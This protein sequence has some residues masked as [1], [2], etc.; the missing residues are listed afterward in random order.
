M[1][2]YAIL[3]AN[4]PDLFDN[5]RGTLLRDGS[6]IDPGDMIHCDGSAAPLTNIYPVEMTAADWAGWSSGGHPSPEVETASTL[7]F[8]CRS[9][10]WVAEVSRMLSEDLAVPIWV[11]DSADN[12]WPADGVDS[13]QLTLD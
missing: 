8:E 7:L 10:A 1:S 5:V 6:F 3:V 11:V 9:P 13:E 2:R 4:D 12:V